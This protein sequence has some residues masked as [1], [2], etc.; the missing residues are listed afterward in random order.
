MSF[1]WFCRASAQI[2]I[3]DHDVIST[4]EINNSS[5]TQYMHQE[6]T[7]IKSLRLLSDPVIQY[8]FLYMYLYYRIKCCF[9]QSTHHSENTKIKLITVLKQRTVL[10]ANLT[11]TTVQS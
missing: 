4:T 9:N 6:I 2:F 10:L 3:L 1:C 7:F 5:L 8:I 11:N